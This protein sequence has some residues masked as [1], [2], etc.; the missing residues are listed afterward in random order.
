MLP[1]YF[2]YIVVHLRQI[3]RLKPEIFVNFRPEPDPK[4][5]ARLTTPN[6]RVLVAVIIQS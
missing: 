2:D 6:V 5:L 4:S 1:S 3:V